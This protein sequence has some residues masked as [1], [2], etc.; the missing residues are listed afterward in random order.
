MSWLFC[1]WAT[2]HAKSSSSSSP[3]AGCWYLIHLNLLILSK[4]ASTIRFKTQFLSTQP[5]PPG[6]R[7]VRPSWTTMPFRRQ[8]GRTLES[9]LRQ[10]RQTRLDTIQCITLG[11]SNLHRMLEHSTLMATSNV[12]VIKNLKRRAATPASTLWVSVYAIDSTKTWW[13]TRSSKSEPRKE[14]WQVVLVCTR[15]TSSSWRSHAAV[16]AKETRLRTCPANPLPR[17]SHAAA[18]RERVSL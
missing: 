10:Q 2:D 6:H 8:V 14:A 18:S 16:Q 15:A 9:A 1:F 5:S 13:A 4:V 11:R 17:H 3:R 12:S 7:L